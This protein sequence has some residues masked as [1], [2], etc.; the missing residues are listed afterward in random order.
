MAHPVNPG[1]LASSLFVILLIPSLVQGAIIADANAD[2]A[3]NVSNP[4]LVNPN[5]VW[6]YG[7]APSLGGVFVPFNEYYTA[8]FGFGWRTNACFPYL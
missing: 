7:Y 4:N 8:G 3:P 6:S 1:I 5:G 2:F